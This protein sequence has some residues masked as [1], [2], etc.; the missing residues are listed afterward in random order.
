MT[1]ITTTIK[2]DWDT[3]SIHQKIGY[4]MTIENPE[5]H[6]TAIMVTKSDYDTANI[7]LIDA[8]RGCITLYDFPITEDGLNKLTNAML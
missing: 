6:D 7:Q 5:P 2:N 1:H 8:N 4:I 3:L